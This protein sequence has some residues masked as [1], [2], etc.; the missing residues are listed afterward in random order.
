MI[1]DKICKG[2]LQV[3]NFLAGQA[4]K[5]IIKA[6]INSVSGYRVIIHRISRVKVNHLFVRKKRTNNLRKK[7]AKVKIQLAETITIK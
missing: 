1:S 5:A 3:S 4:K 7:I 2:M 6:K